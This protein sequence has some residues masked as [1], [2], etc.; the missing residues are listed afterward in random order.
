MTNLLLCGCEPHGHKCLISE[1]GCGRCFEHCVCTPSG[2][3]STGA[4]RAE[5][6]GSPGTPPF[7]P[8]AQS[9]AG[10]HCR[11]PGV[12]A[13]PYRA[14][15]LHRKSPPTASEAFDS[16]GCCSG[17]GNLL[18]NCETL[19]L[20]GRWYCSDCIEG[21]NMKTKT[22][23]Y[24]TFTTQV[25]PEKLDRRFSYWQF[26]FRFVGVPA[27]FAVVLWLLGIL[28]GGA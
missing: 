19:Y 21:K 9:L 26:M 18:F 3:A 28:W 2:V 20:N 17:C 14:A 22:I 1:G 23:R 15:L 4:G 11:V 6:T 13:C 10:L 24:V 16:F 8:L 7:R 5:D 12:V 25:G 27:F